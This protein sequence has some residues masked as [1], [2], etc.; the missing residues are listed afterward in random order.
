MFSKHAEV[1]VY[2]PL[3]LSPKQGTFLGALWIA[4]MKQRDGGLGAGVERAD[5]ADL[6]FTAQNRG[7]L[8]PSIQFFSKEELWR[9]AAALAQLNFVYL[10]ET[11]GTIGFLGSSLMEL[12]T[13]VFRYIK[14]WK[15]AELCNEFTGGGDDR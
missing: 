8:D 12:P 11:G 13:L 5:F 3:I 14:F 6:I 7:L 15:F 10:P 1:V 9:T 2:R 4:V